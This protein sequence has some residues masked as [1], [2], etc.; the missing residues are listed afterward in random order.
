MGWLSKL[1]GSAEPKGIAWRK[2]ENGNLTSVVQGQR[3]TIY[4]DSGGWKFCL[5][6]ADEEREPFFSESY[7]TQDAAQYEAAAMIEGRPS[8]FKSN[9]DLR[10]ERLVQSV[11][12]RLAGEQERLEGVRKSLERA[13]GRAA[14]QVSTLQNI[15]KRLLVGRRMAV[16]VQTDAS[17]WAEDD[18][19]AAAAE[20]MIE[21]YD[22][23]WDDVDDLIASK[24]EVTPKD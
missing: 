16:G 22:A 12:G 4:P 17:I 6:D 3:V 24:I 5:A 14:T 7:A 11:P 20:L 18:R 10:Q 1:F 19:T 23:L 2:S 13:K 21:Q 15:K 9:A 8:R